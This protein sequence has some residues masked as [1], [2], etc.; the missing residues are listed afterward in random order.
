MDGFQAL[1]RLKGAG[2][3]GVQGGAAMQR[4][5]ITCRAD[6]LRAFKWPLLKRTAF[7]ERGA[8]PLSCRERDRVRG[9]TWQDKARR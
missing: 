6:R 3:K 2:F 4:G 7:A 5:R 1:C 9:M 8:G